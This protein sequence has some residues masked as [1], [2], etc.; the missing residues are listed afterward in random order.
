MKLP[1]TLS[2]RRK[3]VALAGASALVVAGLVTLPAAMAHAAPGC[4]I[5]YTAN[6]WTEGAGT[7]GFTAN[8]TVKNTGD[9]LTSWTLR[10]SYANGQTLTLPGWSANWSQS[11]ANVTAASLSYNGSLGTGASTSIGINGRWTGSNT[12]PTSFT[13]N[14]TTCTTGGVTPS[15]STSPSP[16]TQPS[17]STSASPQPRSII[18]SPASVSVAEGSSSSVTVKLSAAPTSNVTVALARSGDTS[19]TAPASVTLTPSNA[20][21]GVSVA[22]AAAEDTDQTNGT[23]TVAASASG[24]TGASLAVTEIDN[25]ITQSG[26]ADNPYVGAT[27]YV[28]PN[29]RSRALAET[30]GSRIANTSTG[31]WLDRIAAIAG[32][33]STMGLRAHLDE[34]VVQDAANGSAR[35]TIQF[36]IYNL[37]G[38]DCSALASNG[39]LG[40]DELPRYKSEYIDPIAAIMSDS[41]YANLRIVAIIEIDSLP[42]LVTNLNIAKCATMNSNGGY[43][44]G[45]G[46]ALTKLGAIPNVYNYIDSAHH[47]WLGWDTNFGP[48]AVKLKEAAVAEGSTVNNVHGFITNTSNYSALTEPFINISGTVGGSPIR[49]SKWIDWNYYADELSFAQAFRSRLVQE[50]FNSNIG[51]LIDTSRNGWGNCVQAPCQP[52]QTT[53]PTAASTSTNVDTYVNQSRIDRRIHAGNW[54]NQAGAGLGERP[55]AAPQPGIDAYVWIKPPGESDGSSSLI[56]NDEGKGFDRMCDP[57]YTGNQLNGNNM[58]GSLPN[59]P[60]SGQWFSAQF[61]QLMA[62]AYPPLS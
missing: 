23:A 29:W 45:V 33:S 21:A 50:G 59:A 20:V 62:N 24:Y 38:R 55:T 46:Y 3:A 39:E 15:P 8:I 43:V 5:T 32:N 31:I 30:G 27:G 7:G 41:K 53:R 48:T 42:N 19:I 60:I 56:P 16:S 36:V 6:E 52:I 61:Q 49:Q 22:I 26:R 58:T 12:K 9:A 44:K 34:A 1:I 54:C 14:N 25:D 37:P 10:Y 35:L 2:G 47:A 11:G 28:N 13:L 51:M 17:P 40:V 4:D 18:I 57:T